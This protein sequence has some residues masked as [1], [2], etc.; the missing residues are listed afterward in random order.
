MKGGLPPMGTAVTEG[1][2][3]VLDAYSLL[4]YLEGSRGAERVRELLDQ[5]KKH[6]VSIAT[7][8]VNI[9]E[10]LSVIERERGLTNAQRVLARFWELPIVR[11]EADE[12]LALA[13]ARCRAERF[14][15]FCDCFAVGLA[16]LLGATLVTGNPDVRWAGDL[17]ELEW[18]DGEPGTHSDGRA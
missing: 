7:S 17:V 1:P 3:Y 2:R 10:A 11:Y 16:Q 12:N 4:A 9:S 15:S 18:L 6:Q 8:V 5:G 13:A 14:V